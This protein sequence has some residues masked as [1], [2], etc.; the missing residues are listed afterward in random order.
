PRRDRFIRPLLGCRRGDL[1]DYLAGLGIGFVDDASNGDVAIP[2]NRVRAELLPLLE[3]RFNPRIVDV[4]ADEAEIAREEWHW[5]QTAAAALTST[6]C[7]REGETL[8]FDAGMI[9]RAPLAIARLALKQAMEEVSGG[10]PVSLRHVTAGLEIFRS[11]AG[12]IDAPVHR[13]ERRGSDVVLR[14]RP[15]SAVAHQGAAAFLYPLTVPGEVEV[16]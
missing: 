10:K 5:L 13:L 14:G 1:R 8:C 2:R 4:L 3:E 15:D 7:R 12:A 11:E 16:P 9:E 6:A